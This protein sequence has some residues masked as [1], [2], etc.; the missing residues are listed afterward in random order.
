MYADKALDDKEPINKKTHWW[1]FKIP[2]HGHAWRTI[3]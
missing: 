1:L 3:P 2:K